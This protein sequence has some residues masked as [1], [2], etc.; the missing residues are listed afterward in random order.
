MEMKPWI[1]LNLWII[2][3]TISPFPKMMA[4]IHL[5]FKTNKNKN[6]PVYKKKVRIL[7]L[8]YIAVMAECLKIIL[9][10]LTK[11]TLPALL[12]SIQYKI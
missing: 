2:N 3:I 12:L 8:A 11:I 1:I 10:W 7:M 9:S 4:F 6:K 5:H